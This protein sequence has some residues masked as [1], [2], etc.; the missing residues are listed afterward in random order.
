[1]LVI[2][3]AKRAVAEFAAELAEL[4]RLSGRPSL[5]RMEVLSK[6][7]KRPRLPHSTA[8]DALA[9]RRLPPIWVVLGIVHAC[10]DSAREDSVE[11][12]IGLFNPIKWQ[13]RWLAVSRL[14]DE[15]DE[16]PA[17]QPLLDHVPPP[18]PTGMMWLPDRTHS[19]YLII[20]NV[21]SPAAPPLPGVAHNIHHMTASLKTAAPWM[22]VTTILDPTREQ[23]T[24]AL[25]AAAQQAEDVLIVHLL[26][27]G[28]LDDRMGLR[29]LTRDSRFDDLSRTALDLNDVI[30]NLGKD[31]NA[32]AF[33]LIVDTCFAGGVIPRSNRNAKQHA[34]VLA[35]TDAHGLAVDGPSSLTDVMASI[36]GRGVS[37]CPFPMLSV[38]H[39]A[40]ECARTFEQRQRDDHR[41]VRQAVT[42]FNQGNANKITFGLNAAA[43]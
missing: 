32:E 3:N 10:L 25:Q 20:G 33:V 38:E 23:A 31:S 6:R 21:S 26:G 18:A 14:C 37:D 30:D 13:D 11:V 7:A 41:L 12:D 5:R 39:L 9:G 43:I 2:E 4:R 1:L 34:F 36:L 42:T 15:Q 19:S 35:A 28:Y 16:Q 8:G 27:H 29:L 17:H 24:F 40:R 22:P